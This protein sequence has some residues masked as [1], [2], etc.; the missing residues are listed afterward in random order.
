MSGAMGVG[1]APVLDGVVRSF[2]STGISVCCTEEGGGGAGFVVP[3]TSSA[4]Y[5]IKVASISRLG[6]NSS[7]PRSSRG[8]YPSLCTTAAATAAADPNCMSPS[9]S[10]VPAVR[11]LALRSR[12]GKAGGATF[13]VRPR[14]RDTVLV[15]GAGE[16]SGASSSMNLPPPPGPPGTYLRRFGG[17][18]E[19]PAGRAFRRTGR[20]AVVARPRGRPRPV[21]RGVVG[22]L[23]ICRFFYHEFCPSPREERPRRG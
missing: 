9:S 2:P 10:W 11:I 7:H 6:W 1:T 21:R 4:W 20:S 14:V 12:R 19:A 18:S 17:G 5:T 13:E 8:L 15:L 22:A 16:L 23:S 3:S